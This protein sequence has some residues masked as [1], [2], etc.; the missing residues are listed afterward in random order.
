MYISNKSNITKTISSKKIQDFFYF[1]APTNL[2]WNTP[3]S[4]SNTFGH[5]VSM[6]FF[7]GFIPFISTTNKNYKFTIL[8]MQLINVVVLLFSGSKGAI[9]ALIV[10]LVLSV[11][12]L[13]IHKKPKFNKYNTFTI[14]IIFLILILLYH[15]NIENLLFY[16]NDNILRLKTISNGT[17]RYN[18]WI[19]LL[20][21]PFISHPFGFNDNYLYLYLKDLN[22]KEYMAFLNNQGRAHNMYLQVLVSYGYITFSLFFYIII[23]LLKRICL[24]YKRIEKSY[25]I[26]FSLF[27]IEFFV[28]LIGGLFE[29][30][31]I[32][33]LSTHSLIFML[34][35]S[36]L[37]TLS[38]I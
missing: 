11:P 12:I 21:L 13:I 29:Q 24:S 20:K 36:N 2:R 33:N 15:N 28:I 1:C 8:F 31:P 30:L 18:I 4:N 37:L 7:I 23:K 17:G 38:D 6:T 19:G 27:T 35:C 16:F 22:I 26:I 3:L 9:F 14:I 32:N 10:G 5:L 34:I 25:I